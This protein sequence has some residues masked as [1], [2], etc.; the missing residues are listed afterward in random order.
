MRERLEL[1]NVKWWQWGVDIST[2]IRIRYGYM[3]PRPTEI[4]FEA[5]PASSCKFTF[6]FLPSDFGFSGALSLFIY[7]VFSLCFRCFCEG[8]ALV[9]FTWQSEYFA[10]KFN[11]YSDARRALSA[12]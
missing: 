6:D 5:G 2:I 11:I 12:S 8:P 4:M 9:S 3:W 10:Y 7:I 1:G